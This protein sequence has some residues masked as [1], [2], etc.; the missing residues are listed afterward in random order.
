MLLPFLFLV[1]LFLPP[2]HPLID[3]LSNW[4]SNNQG[5]HFHSDDCD[6]KLYWGIYLLQSD[7]RNQ[8]KSTVSHIRSQALFMKSGPAGLC[9]GP[10]SSK[11]DCFSFPSE[12]TQHFK[13]S[14]GVTALAAVQKRGSGNICLKLNKISHSHAPKGKKKNKLKEHQEADW[15]VL[16]SHSEARQI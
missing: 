1:F 5:D 10:L 7:Q 2:S 3:P 12:N 14:W 11:A 8:G 6:E 9:Q 15:P 13:A 4:V 16:P